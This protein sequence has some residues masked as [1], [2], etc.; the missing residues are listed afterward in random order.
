M[1]A[2]TV[3]A[4]MRQGSCVHA[5]PDVFFPDKGGS[6]AAAKAVCAGCP[7]R[8]DCL[9]YALANSERFGVW[10]GLSERERR[11]LPQPAA[12][13]RPGART[14]AGGDIAVPPGALRTVAS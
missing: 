12:P 1:I 3:P 9:D 11:N 13:S 8:T 2:L 5:D 7:V 14:T 6:A 4:W 10:G